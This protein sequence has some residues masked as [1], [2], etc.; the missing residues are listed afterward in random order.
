[1]AARIVI[2]NGSGGCG[3]STFISLCKDICDKNYNQKQKQNEHDSKD[4]NNKNNKSTKKDKKKN[5]KNSPKSKIVME[6]STVDY[7]KEVAQ[8][9]GWK[10]SKTDKD[11]SFLH[12]LKEALAKWNNSPNQ[13][14][15]DQIN[16]LQEARSIFDK[17]DWLFFVNIR[18]PE[19]IK[20]FIEQNKKA[21]GLPVSTLLIIN[22]NVPVIQS[23]YADRNVEHYNYDYIVSN[24]SDIASLRSR[25]EN[26]LHSVLKFI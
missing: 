16:S 4:K 6:L 18:E 21:T 24:S 3:K 14:V 1:M 10:G 26:Y 19:A 22:F 5:P 7:V 8:Y 23:N 2:I 20:E 12:E 15:F 11:R 25:A 9:C 13:K 17:S